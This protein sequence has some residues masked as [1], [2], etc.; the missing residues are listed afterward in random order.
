MIQSWG[1]KG[2][3]L[4]VKEA[5]ELGQVGELRMLDRETEQA[6][7]EEIFSREDTPTDQRVEPAFLYHAGL[8]YRR[9]ER[10]VGRSHEAVRQW[11]HRLAHLFDPALDYHAIVAVDETKVSL[12]DDEV[13]V[14]AAVD[15]D[16]FGVVHIEVFPGR[17]DLDALL[18]LKTVLKRCRGQPVIVVDRGPRH[19]WAIDDLDLCESRRET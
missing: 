3:N 1:H 7:E 13:Y 18:F 8:S 5:V 17:S 4:S 14:W 15:V 9:V 19:N 11:Y 6:R 16:T 10:V 12:E 2:V